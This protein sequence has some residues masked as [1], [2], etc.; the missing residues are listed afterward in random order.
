MTARR[1][2]ALSAAGCVLALSLVAGSGCEREIPVVENQEVTGYRIEGLVTDAQ[3]QPVANVQ[4]KLFYQFE[5]VDSKPPPAKTYIVPQSN[6]LIA[7][8]VYDYGDR[9]IRTISS[10]SYPAGP[11][12]IEWDKKDDRGN[13]VPSGVYWVRYLSGNDVHLRYPVTISGEVATTTNSSGRYV[14]PAENLPI[15]FYPVPLYNGDRSQYF[16]NHRIIPYVGLDFIISNSRKSVSFL[17]QK[18]RVTHM[19]VRFR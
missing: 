17:L 10:I 6:Q 16:G 1:M 2:I 9:V 3:G 7:A 15:G 5:F 11:I 8:R 14:I 13:L 12:V 18:D 4:V 19:D